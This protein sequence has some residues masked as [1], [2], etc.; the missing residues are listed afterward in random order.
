MCTSPL[1]GFKIG[2]N[3]ENGKNILKVRSYNV[4][5]I[6]NDSGR[7][8]DSYMKLDGPAPNCVSDFIE[9]PCGQCLECRLQRSRQ[10]ADRCVLE[11]QYHEQSLFLTLTYD[12]D[13][14]P[15]N[16]VTVPETGEIVTV[17]TLVK[18]DLSKFMKALRQ[19]Y[20]YKHDNQLRFFGCGEYGSET[21]RP[22]YH[23]IVFGLLLDD[24]KHH[25]RNF[26][27]DDFYTSDTISKV[28]KKGFHVISDCTWQA[29]AYTARYIMKKHLGTD[30]D[31]YEKHGL[32]PEFVNM[33]RR[34]GIA[35]Q[36]Y[37]DHPEIFEKDFISVPTHQGGKD[38][39]PP[40]YFERLFESDFPDQAAVRKERKRELMEEKKEQILAN[41]DLNYLDYLK[42]KEYN[43][44]RKMKA[45]P[46]KEI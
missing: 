2:I 42:Q 46:R 26:Q 3:P 28:W 30:A 14:L 33:S 29:C 34:P 41:T 7:W 4:E 35:R 43:I 44:D 9:I 39:F 1:K 12:D 20:A 13:H 17:G 6:H 45:L 8:M 10:W 36:Y 38:I 31:Y 18:D 15:T 5:F 40:K 25:H 37:D 24:L 27:G 23:V 11:Q 21:H 19:E 16:E 32:V 22:H